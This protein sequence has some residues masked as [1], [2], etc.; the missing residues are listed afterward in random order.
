MA[1]ITMPC[2]TALA[3]DK[4]VPRNRATFEPDDLDT[5]LLP[6]SQSSR[7]SEKCLFVF[8]ASQT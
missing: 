7:W 4:R 3:C 2:A 1:F 5:V 8:I 6:E